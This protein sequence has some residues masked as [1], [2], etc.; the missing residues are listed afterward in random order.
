MAENPLY[1]QQKKRPRGRPFAKGQSGN[2]G[3][4]PAGAKNRA[5]LLAEQLLDGEAAALARK[6][7]DMALKG[8]PA[9][10]RLCF[11]RILAPRRERPA[12]FEM[13]PVKDAADLGPAMAAVAAAAA[14]GTI[15]PAEAWEFSQVLETYMR[16]VAA[17]DFERRLQQLEEARRQEAGGGP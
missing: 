9:A 4:K 7:L 12:R 14:E 17:S 11:D 10:M 5:T 2:P 16:A 3:G 6:A 8:D 13:P 15:T 1:L